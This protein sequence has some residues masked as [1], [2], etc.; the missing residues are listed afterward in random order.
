MNYVCAAG[1]GSFVEEQANKLGF[2]VDEIGDRVLG[3]A[4]PFTSERCTVF[5]ERDVEKLL[6]E[7][8]SRDDAMAAVLYSVCFNYLTKVVGH[9]PVTGKKIL[10]QGATAKNK[11]LV[12]AFE[13]ILEREIVTS[14]F[15]HVTGAIGAAS[16]AREEAAASGR[17]SSFLGLDLHKRE[18]RVYYDACGLCQNHCKITHARIEGEESEPSW[19]YMC[20]REPEETKKKPN[21]LYQ[22]FE[23][24]KRLFMAPPASGEAKEDSLS[25]TMPMALATY[26]HLPL[27]RTFFRELGVNLQTTLPTN[28]ETIEAGI[29]GSTAEFCF[30]IK[31]LLGHVSR[32]A[33]SADHL[34]IPHLIAGE[35][36]RITIKSVFC[37]YVQAAPSI[38]R[39]SEVLSEALRDRL[40]SPVIDFAMPDEINVKQ[41]H[42]ALKPFGIRKGRIA[43][44]WKAGLQAL[45]AYR[46]ACRREGL[47]ILEEIE[48]TGEKAV[49]MVGRY[50]NLYDGGINLEIPRKISEMG[51]RVIPY[52]FL[53]FSEEDLDPF[54]QNMFWYYGQRILNAAR[55]V[56][57]RKNLFLVYLTNFSCGPDSFL[58]TYVDEIMGNKP[59]LT[60]ELDEHSADT[61][62]GTRLEAFAD[63]MA[64]Y[65]EAPQA[66][67]RLYI[68]K[69]AGDLHDKRVLL[70][71]MHVG[72]VPMFAAAFE[73]HGYETLMLPE[74]T[75]EQFELGRKHTRGSECLPAHVTTGSLLNALEAY[76]LRPDEAALFMPTSDGPC[77]FGQYAYLHRIVANKLGHEDLTIISPSAQNAYMGLEDDLRKDLWKGILMG[78]L[79]LKG[80]CRIAPFEKNA[81]ETRREFESILRDSADSF[82]GG[83]AFTRVLEDAVARFSRIER[84][85]VSRPLV[86]IVGEIF[87]R[88]NPFSCDRVV[89][90]VLEAGAEPW[91]APM[92]EWI[93]FTSFI[94]R[95]E[96]RKTKNL[97][98]MVKSYLSNSFLS[99]L[100]HKAQEA[101]GE[102]LRARREPPTADMVEAGE[103]Y[104]PVEFNA[105]AILSAGRAELFIDR[106]GADMIVNVSPFTCMPGTITAAVFRQ[107]SAEKGVPIVNMYYDG[108]EGVNEK[109]SIFL[110]NL[111]NKAS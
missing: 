6:Q 53:P 90:W 89:D 41:L 16:L 10:F 99:R 39:S 66:K 76:N 63:L 33:R 34:F 74:I 23:V 26:A 25:L 70:V 60:L 86:G 44:A 43:R 71:P 47:R 61:G 28:R 97:A 8:F 17:G 12:A 75:P 52:E 46:Q 92:S 100:E 82:R 2:R 73:K 32:A 104:F 106:D 38:V 30:P 83:E 108:T 58:L 36:T 51:Y 102:L 1:T 59:S 19:G 111:R 88:C 91:L 87:V 93:L 29:S 65:E 95:Y 77:R 18:V 103:K 80:Y 37:P 42:A 96:A 64:E 94:H 35:K 101:T 98:E 105:E 62:Y 57:D 68:K 84:A 67:N 50:Y 110:K 21:D 45:E 49:V 56:R 54:F 5:M 3:I 31:I 81:G 22:P 15:C 78:D 4:P 7:G 20:G 109:I 48:R 24:R 13:I 69:A 40:L 55:L 9:R 14:A 85:E 79:L 11:G 107:M 72:V 27:W